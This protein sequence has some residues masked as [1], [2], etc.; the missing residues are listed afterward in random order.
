MPRML[1][2]WMELGTLEME[3]NGAATGKTT[4]AS[5]R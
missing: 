4:P 5:R 1:S 2:L 3:V